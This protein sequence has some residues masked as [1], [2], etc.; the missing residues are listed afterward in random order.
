MSKSTP[1]SIPLL[2]FTEIIILLVV[3]INRYHQFLENADDG[4]SPECEV[5]EVEMFAFLAL[6]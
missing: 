2:F 4:S 3:E 5:T 6:P 1:I